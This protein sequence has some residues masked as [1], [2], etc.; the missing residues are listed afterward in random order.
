MRIPCG[1]A[2]LPFGQAGA[3]LVLR[4]YRAEL[5]LPTALDGGVSHDVMA[6]MT[7]EGRIAMRY[8]TLDGRAIGAGLPLGRACRRAETTRASQ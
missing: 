3:R 5:R 7:T 1:G 6:Q 4:R 8:V 2:K